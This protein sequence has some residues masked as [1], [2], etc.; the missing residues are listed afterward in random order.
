MPP[1]G[2]S[3]D[4]RACGGWLL[5]P[6]A[7]T[8]GCGTVGFATA[9]GTGPV[10]SAA[11]LTAAGTVDLAAGSRDS[12]GGTLGHLTGGGVSPVDFFDVCAPPEP[13]AIPERGSSPTVSVFN[14]EPPGLCCTIPRR[15]SSNTSVCDGKS[16]EKPTGLFDRDEPADGAESGNDPV[17]DGG[18]GLS[19]EDDEPAPSGSANATPGRGGYRRPN[20]KRNR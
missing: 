16:A 3:G 6:L 15:G 20:T 7:A 2:C 13:W 10:G 11:S 17:C 1:S 4:A 12:R 5:E 8:E 14:A 19:D 9:T 18:D